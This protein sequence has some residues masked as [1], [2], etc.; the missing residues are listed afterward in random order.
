MRY[1]QPV[2]HLYR[3]AYQNPTEHANRA[4]NLT[5]PVQMESSQSK[6]MANESKHGSSIR[7]GDSIKNHQHRNANKKNLFTLRQSESMNTLFDSMLK[8]YR[9]KQVLITT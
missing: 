1:L 8:Q 4:L 2:K 9:D 6:K 7:G 5:L 3:V